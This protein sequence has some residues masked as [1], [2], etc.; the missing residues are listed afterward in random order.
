MKNKLGI[1]IMT[2]NKG[3]YHFTSDE[4]AWLHIREEDL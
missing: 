3:L 2:K 1:Y 4:I